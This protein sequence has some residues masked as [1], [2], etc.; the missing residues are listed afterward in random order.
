MQTNARAQSAT[1]PSTV[2]AFS[3]ALVALVAFVLGA[4]LWFS[5]GVHE[6]ASWS[7][8]RRIV[9]WS[10]SLSAWSSGPSSP[11]LAAAG[12]DTAATRA[13]GGSLDAGPRALPALPEAAFDEPA[14]LAIEPDDDNDRLDGRGRDRVALPSGLVEPARPAVLVDPDA[15]ALPRAEATT[16]SRERLTLGNGFPR[17]PPGV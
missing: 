2:R 1:R 9:F 4:G 3:R 7:V 8:A 13:G 10:P 11:A 12:P 5:S 14:L 16:R 15:A 17:G 6:S